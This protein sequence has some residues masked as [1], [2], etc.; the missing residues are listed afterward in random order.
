MAACIV[1]PVM[2]KGSASCE[3]IADVAACH[4]P[5]LHER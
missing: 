5:K 4:V 1:P 3:V 2:R